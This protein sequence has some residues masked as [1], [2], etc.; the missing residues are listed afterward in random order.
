MKPLI[1][2]ERGASPSSSSLELLDIVASDLVGEAV[3][4]SGSDEVPGEDP[5]L[6]VT[7]SGAPT[8]ELKSEGSWAACR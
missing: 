5:E 8:E 1:A 7:S 4:A 3:E 2:V 6:L